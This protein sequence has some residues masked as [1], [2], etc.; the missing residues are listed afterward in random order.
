[1]WQKKRVF[2]IVEKGIVSHD[3]EKYIQNERFEK[4]NARMYE[5]VEIWYNNV[6]EHSKIGFLN[7]KREMIIQKNWI[8][9]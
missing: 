9:F 3:I 8:I 4:L 1:M 2:F 5:Y 7:L 6:R